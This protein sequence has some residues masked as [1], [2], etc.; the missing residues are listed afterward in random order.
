ML[1]A[2]SSLQEGGGVEGGWGE[3]RL[4]EIESVLQMS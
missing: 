3:L 4:T 2:G 1:W